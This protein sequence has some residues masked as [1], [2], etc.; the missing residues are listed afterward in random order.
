MIQKLQII[1]A[2]AVFIVVSQPSV[3]RFLA[4][5]LNSTTCLKEFNSRHNKADQNSL[6]S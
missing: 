5:V 6:N 2:K 4:G 1:E 3:K